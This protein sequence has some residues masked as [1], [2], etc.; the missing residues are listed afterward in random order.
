MD[1][2]RR[3]TCVG[4]GLIGSG[5]AAL[6]A[7]AGLEVTATDTGDGAEERLRAA[8]AAAWPALR[9]LG[10]TAAAEPAGIVFEAELERAVAVADWVQESTPDFPEQK[11]ALIRRVAAATPGATVIASSTSGILPSM[12]QAGCAH[13][14]RVLVGH[15]FN[16]AHIVPLV[17][18]VAGRETAPETVQRAMDFYA[19]LGKKPL[20]CRVEAPGFIA[21]RLQEAMWREMFHLVNDGV[22]TTSELDAAVADGPGLRWALYGP[23]L[24]YMMQGG[25]GG[26]A[27]ALEQFAPELVADCSHNFYP[28][29]TPELKQAL[30]E[31]TREEAGGRSLEELQAL[32]DEFLVRVIELRAALAG[33]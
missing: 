1:D 32:R 23:A 13:P 17:E 33:G 19:G 31:Q 14:E 3:V 5:W 6:F 27:Y 20:H 26:F 7:A 30:D 4:T 29:V 25:P 9:R 15:P 18:V 24:I 22:A 10:V 2:V 16:P 8:V 28:E 12:L 21:N 11:A